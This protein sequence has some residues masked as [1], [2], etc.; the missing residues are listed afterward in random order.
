[1]AYKNKQMVLKF[2]V[3]CH[4]FGQLF[5]NRRN[6]VIRSSPIFCLKTKLTVLSDVH[7]DLWT[8]EISLWLIFIHTI[9]SS[10][11]IK[12][13]SLFPPFT[14]MQIKRRTSCVCLQK[15]FTF[16]KF[17]PF[18]FYLFIHFNLETDSFRK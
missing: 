11:H 10:F 7:C 3:L 12:A 8:M 14:Q 5:L 18:F 9:F 2:R 6:N 15:Y 4:E 17:S 16:G 13:T 1:M